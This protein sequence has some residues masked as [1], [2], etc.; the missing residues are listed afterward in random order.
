MNGWIATAQLE[1][2][3][4]IRPAA[5]DL[6]RLRS[7]IRRKIAVAMIQAVLDRKRKA[8]RA[9]GWPNITY[10]VPQG[11]HCSR[12]TSFHTPDRLSI[13]FL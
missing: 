10:A 8:S 11:A 6:L 5:E 7:S 4:R 3:R 1:I 13:S 12:S 2:Y 9:A